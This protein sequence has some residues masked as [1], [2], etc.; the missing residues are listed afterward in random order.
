MG[1]LQCSV[2]HKMHNE[3]LFTH[4]DLQGVEL[5]IAQNSF[6]I[7]EGCP[8]PTDITPN[9]ILMQVPT[10]PPI[11]QPIDAANLNQAPRKVRTNAV[12][13]TLWLAGF[14]HKD[15]DELDVEGIEVDKNNEPAQENMTP[16]PE[17]VGQV[18]T[19]KVPNTCPR[20]VGDFTNN[21]GKS[22]L[23]SWDIVVGIDGFS[24]GWHV[25][26]SST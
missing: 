1:R 14:T 12:P 25:F 24:F 21:S 3:Y 20:A 13:N 22:N 16:D 18:G 23:F 5:C 11:N 15:F 26:T 9:E 17:A 8:G 2:W 7:D 10:M 6:K 4:H 19:L